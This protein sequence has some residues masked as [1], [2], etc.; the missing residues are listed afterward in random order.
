LGTLG[1]ATQGTNTAAARTLSG[2]VI[3]RIAVGKRMVMGTARAKPVVK[4]TRARSQVRMTW[5]K[6]VHWRKR[7]LEERMVRKEEEFLGG[8]L[9]LLLFIILTSLDLTTF[10]SMQSGNRSEYRCRPS[11]SHSISASFTNTRSTSHSAGL[12]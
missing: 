10:E 2:E 3:V 5:S 9:M 8:K 1:I 12:R 4:R 11:T 6:V 7:V